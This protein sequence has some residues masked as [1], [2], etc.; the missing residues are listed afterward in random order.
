MGLGPSVD[1]Q[2]SPCM[3]SSTTPKRILDGVDW[4]ATPGAFPCV[5]GEGQT[6]RNV[7]HFDFLCSS[8]YIFL[9]YGPTFLNP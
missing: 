7:G 6:R 1:V 4:N 3:Y 5:L 8:W 2:K 9:G